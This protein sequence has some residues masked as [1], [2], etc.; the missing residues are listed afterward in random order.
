MQSAKYRAISAV[1]LTVAMASVHAESKPAA[2][3]ATARDL[4][5]I[6]ADRM[7]YAARTALLEAQSAYEAKVP[8][9]A[10]VGAVAQSVG[11]PTLTRIIGVNGIMF[12][13]F[14][15]ADGTAIERAVGE[16]IPGD[17]TVLHLWPERA[18]GELRDKGG[19]I[20]TVGSSQT[21]SLSAARAQSPAAGTPAQFIGGQMPSPMYVPSIGGIQR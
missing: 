19:K 7:M 6:Q 1:V 8:A 13:R 17:F 2:D 21:A 18:A 9:V 20:I 15:Y 4:A 3:V 14:Q 12:G 10:A 5:K 16:K 11:V